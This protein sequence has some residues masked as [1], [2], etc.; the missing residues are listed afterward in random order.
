MAE[1]VGYRRGNRFRFGSTVMV[2]KN[3]T[4]GVLATTDP[5]SQPGHAISWNIQMLPI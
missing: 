4:Q 5:I 1:P 2:T 3:N